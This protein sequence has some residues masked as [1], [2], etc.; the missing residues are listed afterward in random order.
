MFKIYLCLSV[1]FK[2]LRKG[3][4]WDQDGVITSANE[5]K[6]ASR[7]L[8]QGLKWGKALKFAFPNSFPG[9]S[10]FCIYGIDV[11]FNTG[12][13]V[14]ATYKNICKTHQ[15]NLAICKESGSSS[16]QMVLFNTET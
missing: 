5:C 2:K 3:N 13:N 4:F 12:E 11:Y 10:V 14:A 15:D 7:I 1:V 6:Q 9:C 16:K 8:N